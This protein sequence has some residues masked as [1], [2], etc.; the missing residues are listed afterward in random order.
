MDEI[1]QE[2]RTDGD[3]ILKLRLVDGRGQAGR[4]SICKLGS[5]SFLSG[6]KKEK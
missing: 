6:H 3:E 4:Q 5:G 2:Q 1:I